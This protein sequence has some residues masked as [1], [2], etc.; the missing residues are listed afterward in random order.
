M[1]DLINKLKQAFPP[2]VL[3]WILTV[4][5]PVPEPVR[6]IVSTAVDAVRNGMNAAVHTMQAP[7]PGQ[8]R[9]D[10]VAKAH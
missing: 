5:M 3:G 2:L 8:Q 6:A 1:N 4:W 10:E 9:G 7:P